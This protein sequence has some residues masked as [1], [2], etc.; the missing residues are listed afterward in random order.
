MTK[1]F[2]CFC[3][4]SP[5]T[6]F[7][8][9]W[10]A[11]LCGFTAHP[12]SLQTLLDGLVINFGVL[13]PTLSGATW[14]AESTVSVS[15]S[16]N[17]VQT[18]ALFTVS[19]SFLSTHS[20]D[21][22]L[23]GLEFTLRIEYPDSAPCNRKISIARKIIAS[24]NSATP[25]LGISFYDTPW[26]TIA[27][28][29]SFYKQ[30][31]NCLNNFTID[32]GF[33]IGASALSHLGFYSPNSGG[34]YLLYTSGFPNGGTQLSPRPNIVSGVANIQHSSMFASCL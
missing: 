33:P 10:Y 24:Y 16:Q 5:C 27:S 4:C 8:Q 26:G 23:D 15:Y 34:R 11:Q 28:S 2:P 6:D 3:Q 29:T 17:L 1:P 25:T 12:S 20:V 30:A 22:D 13:T 9:S 21:F 31:D 14:S 32:P 18:M 7:A 19:G